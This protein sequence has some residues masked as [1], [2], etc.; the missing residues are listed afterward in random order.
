VHGAALGE[1]EVAAT[2]ASIGWTHPPFV[3]PDAVYA[4]WNARE[5]GASA[6][7]EWAKRFAHYRAAHPDL[8]AEFSRR[9]HGELPAAWGETASAFVHA[10]DTKGETVATRKASQHAIEAYAK[11]LPEMIGGSA[12][13]TGSVFT[14]WSG[15][16]PVTRDGPGNYV[17]FGVREFAMCAIANGMA[18]HGGLI[19][20][21]GTFLTFSDYARNAL[22]MTALMKLRSIFV[23]THDSIGLGEDGP[24]HQSVEHAASLRLI[25]NMDVWRPCDTVETAVAWAAAIERADGPACL[26]FSRQN[27]PFQSRDGA[28]IAAVRRGGYVL[29]DW[30]SASLTRAV[31]IATGSEVA[32]AMGARAVLAGEGVAVRVVSMPCTSVFDRQDGAYRAGVLPPGVP[33]VAVEAGSTAG[34]HKYVGAI[35]DGRGA[36]V[37]LDTFGESAPAGVLFKHFGFTIENVVAAVKRV[38][39]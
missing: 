26:L 10:Q 5:R 4:G 37:G 34:W 38:V 27:V 29:A 23:F 17:N 18:L 14:N 21:V 24:T 7:D 2:R 35:D 33:R 16:K 19:P 28:Q 6:E 9:M 39:A 11:A 30:N 1:K 25:P 13:L 12:D 3:I 22:R 36:V 32:L 8:A 20:Y 31:I 15:S